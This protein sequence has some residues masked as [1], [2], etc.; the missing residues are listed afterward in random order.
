VGI[1]DK[2]VDGDN[3]ML[4]DQSFQNIEDISAGISEHV[5]EY[6]YN[7]LFRGD[8]LNNT[9]SFYIRGSRLGLIGGPSPSFRNYNLIEI[10]LGDIFVP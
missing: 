9:I 1:L 3:V 5:H 4:L 10:D 2:I 7:A 8:L 6:F